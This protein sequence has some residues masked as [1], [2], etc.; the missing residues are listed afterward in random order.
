ML[1]LKIAKNTL[2]YIDSIFKKNLAIFGK[3][4]EFFVSKMMQSLGKLWK[5][6]REHAVHWAD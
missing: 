6:N 5:N 2:D 1:R 3:T 4:I